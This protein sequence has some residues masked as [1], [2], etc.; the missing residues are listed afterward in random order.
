MVTAIKTLARPFVI[1]AAGVAVT[2]GLFCP[3]VSLDKLGVVA[4]LAGF[5]GWLRGQDKKAGGA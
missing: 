3:W 2:I 1:Y 4:A 5:H